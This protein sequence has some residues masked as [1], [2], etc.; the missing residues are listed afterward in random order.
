VRERRISSEKL[1][2]KEPKQRNSREKLK[3]PLPLPLPPPLQQT[4][5]VLKAKTERLKP[6]QKTQRRPRE[7][8]VVLSRHLSSIP[9]LPI[10]V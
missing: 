4:A 6:Q 8:K 3:L 10:C 9:S 7:M 5:M 1:Q 2:D